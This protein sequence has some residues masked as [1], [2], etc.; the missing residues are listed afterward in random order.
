MSAEMTVRKIRVHPDTVLRQKAKKV[1]QIDKSI[2][3]LIDDMIETMRSVSGVGLAAPQVGVSLKVA[4]IEIPG[5]EVI[6]MV[7]PEIMKREGERIIGEACL[8]VPG[9][10]GEVK[11]SV[12]VKVKAQDRLGHKIRL[13]GE[14]LLAQALEHE[15]DHLDGI[16]YVDRLDGPD[17][18]QKSVPDADQEGL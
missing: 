13:K 2:Q 11:R 16:L 18:L 7:N 9:Y 5:D 3:R 12:R 8:S 6:V 10:Q 4:V 17:K 15:I 1:T 14:D